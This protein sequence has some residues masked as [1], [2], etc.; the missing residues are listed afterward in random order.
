MSETRVNDIVK[1]NFNIPN[2]FTPNGDG[3]NDIWVIPY[4]NYLYN[5]I[6]VYN[7]YGSMVYSAINYQNNWDGTMGGRT[8]NM[9]V[10][11]Y[12]IVADNKDTI[13]G[14]VTIVK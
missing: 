5:T 12:V 6:K 4:L 13:S 1:N 10:Y 8:L 7:R 2:T 3:V 14:N 11:Y 9:G